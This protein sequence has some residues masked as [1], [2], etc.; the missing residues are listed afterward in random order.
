MGSAAISDAEAV[1]NSIT[2]GFKKHSTDHK[3]LAGTQSCSYLA[4]W[5]SMLQ[6][7]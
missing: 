7:C 2:T 3:R 4:A 1:W 5:D 6:I